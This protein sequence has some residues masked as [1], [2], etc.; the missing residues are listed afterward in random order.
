MGYAE[1]IAEAKKTTFQDRIV[2]GTV[3]IAQSVLADPPENDAEQRIRNFARRV[4]MDPYAYAESFA[5]NAAVGGA[6]TDSST[7]AEILTRLQTLWLPIAA[8]A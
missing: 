1:D 5:I 6:V 2:I 3:L 7:D 8:A 4:A